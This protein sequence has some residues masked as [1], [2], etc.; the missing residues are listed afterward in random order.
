M[1][2]TAEHIA[3]S[4]NPLQLELRI[5]ANHGG[6]ER[7]EFLRG[8]WKSTWQALKPLPKPK[9]TNALSL[10]DYESSEDEEKVKA[11]RRERARLWK[12]RRKLNQT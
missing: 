10:L 7:F 11:E 8:R 2:K 1:K 6:D 5:L 3:A 9:P 12:E 4:P